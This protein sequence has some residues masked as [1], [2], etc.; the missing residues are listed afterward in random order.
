MGLDEQSTSENMTEYRLGDPVGEV[1]R[2]HIILEIHYII[3]EKRISL[4]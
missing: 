1:K 3:A 4:S 2:G